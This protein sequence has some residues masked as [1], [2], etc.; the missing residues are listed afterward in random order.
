MRH[1]LP[2][3]AS[4]VHR[5]GD[6]ERGQDLRDQEWLQHITLTRRV[7]QLEVDLRGRSQLPGPL[8]LRAEQWMQRGRLMCRPARTGV[9]RAGGLE[10]LLLFPLRGGF[11]AD[12]LPA[13]ENRDRQ[14]RVQPAQHAVHS[15]WGCG[16][17]MN[18]RP[19]GPD[20]A[21]IGLQCSGIRRAFVVQ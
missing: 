12:G 20:R 10:R 16:E 15:R 13:E 18:H 3:P 7:H 11:G 21:G 2:Q 14:L 5:R 1:R 6:A 19:P 8:H 4:G 9:V 17:R